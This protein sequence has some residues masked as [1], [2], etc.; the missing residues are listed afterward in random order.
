ME[1]IRRQLIEQHCK[2]VARLWRACE[3]LVGPHS[4]ACQIA[5]IIATPYLE[6][7]PLSCHSVALIISGRI[8]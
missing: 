7:W 8:P 4:Q 3:G 6:L 2:V 1:I 5:T